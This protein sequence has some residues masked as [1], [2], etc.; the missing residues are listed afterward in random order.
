MQ[1]LRNL[2]CLILCM[3]LVFPVR[4]VR[5]ADPLPELGD[6]DPVPYLL[7]ESERRVEL[8]NSAPIDQKRDLRLE[9]APSSP[10]LMKPTTLLKRYGCRRVFLYKGKLSSVDSYNRVDGENLRPILS[11][12]PDSV[13][14]LNEYQKNRR[15]VIT[16]AYVS[17]FGILL[18]L[19]SIIISG[20]LHP[21][22]K[23]QVRA[24][25]MISGLTLSIGSAVYSLAILRLNESRLPKAVE[26]YNQVRPDDPIVLQF[27]TGLLF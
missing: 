5:S 3:G 17:S 10:N 20:H 18:V 11:L 13:S 8:E 23:N 2:L 16:G 22:R 14:E 26:K 9:S 6:C 24:I 7:D 12:V 21:P 15:K 25:G 19:S 1:L 27:S 4:P